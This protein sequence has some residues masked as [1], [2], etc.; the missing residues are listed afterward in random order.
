M[1]VKERRFEDTFKT[2]VLS[3]KKRFVIFVMNNAVQLKKL[4]D[5]FRAVVIGSRQLR[6]AFL[7]ITRMSIIHDEADTITKHSNVN[8]IVDAQPVSHS[9]WLEFME[10]CDDHMPHVTWKRVFVTATP[11]NCCVMYN[12]TSS[13][14]FA[15][16]I[17]DTYR[18]YKDIDY[19]QSTGQSHSCFFC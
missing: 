6:R 11:E 18:G 16:Q 7:E 10:L 9:A 3:R 2:A 4:M 5:A 17:P 13:A 14:V 12:I 15:L 19:G 1:C 8:T